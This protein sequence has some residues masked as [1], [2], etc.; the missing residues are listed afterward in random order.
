[1]TLRSFVRSGDTTGVRKAVASLFGNDL[2]GRASVLSV[3]QR[4]MNENLARDWWS[5][6]ERRVG[7][8]C[9]LTSEVISEPTS[10][11]RRDELK[12]HPT[13]SLRALKQTLRRSKVAPAPIS[14]TL[15]YLASGWC[16]MIADV[17]CSGSICQF[18]V[19]SHPIREGSSSLNSSR[20]PQAPGTRGTR[21]CSGFRDSAA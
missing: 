11:R 7:T 17:D 19:N 21:S 10:S 3:W 1:V 16:T 8:K 14:H 6:E 18:S 13:R 4:S 12:T 15:K 20:G 9:R 2:R 5:T